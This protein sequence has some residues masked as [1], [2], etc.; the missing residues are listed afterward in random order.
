MWKDFFFF[1]RA[2]R[3]G[4]IV[5][6]IL[7]IFTVVLRF[8]LPLFLHADF[9]VDDP[10]LAKEF[11]DFK[12]KL[13]LEDSIQASEYDQKSKLRDSLRLV[14]YDSVLAESYHS[15]KAKFDS[16]KEYWSAKRKHF[17]DSIH[18]LKKNKIPPKIVLIDINSADTAELFQIA[19]VRKFILKSLWIY[20]DRLGGF[21]DPSQFAEIYNIYPEELERLQTCLKIDPAS[22]RK[23]EINK[24]TVSQLKSH[25]Y[26]NFYQAK[27]VYELRRNKGQLK[28]IE[29]L[30]KLSDFNASDLKKIE[31]YLKF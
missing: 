2:Q 14:H 22:L 12:A 26:L 6:L 30:K 27:A 24:A 19:A 15:K 28:N 16:V 7:L 9:E 23:I 4:V 20:R 13:K 3:A 5:L 29:D 8:A 18:S 31:P 25:P 10:E 11:A 17:S 21:H 1:S